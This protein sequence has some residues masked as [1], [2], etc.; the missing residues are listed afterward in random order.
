LEIF[1][2]H[3]GERLPVVGDVSGRQLVGSISKTDLILALADINRSAP[4]D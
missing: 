4:E 3:D 2:N 1:T